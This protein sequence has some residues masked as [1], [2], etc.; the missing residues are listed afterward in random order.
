MLGGL[1]ESRSGRA[2][3]LTCC[4]EAL[5]EGYLKS[6][7]RDSEEGSHEAK[8]LDPGSYCRVKEEPEVIST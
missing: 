6:F 3:K 8:L 7:P 4:A 5:A 2:L 1:G